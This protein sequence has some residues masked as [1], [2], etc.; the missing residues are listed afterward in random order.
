MIKELNAFKIG[1]YTK[2][3]KEI[4]KSLTLSHEF[5]NSLTGSSDSIMMNNELQNLT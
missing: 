1:E 5:M 2:N 4:A 3:N